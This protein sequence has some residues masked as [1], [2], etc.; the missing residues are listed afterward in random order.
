MF[1]T[2]ALCAVAY[3]IKVCCL[4]TSREPTDHPELSTVKMTDVNKFVLNRDLLHPAFS[5]QRHFHGLSLL[6]ACLLAFLFDVYIRWGAFTRAR[7]KHQLVCA[8]CMRSNGAPHRETTAC[9]LCPANHLKHWRK[10]QLAA[11][12]QGGLQGAVGALERAGGRLCNL[13][14]GPLHTATSS[15]SEEHFRCEELP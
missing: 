12:G 11:S 13:Q 9:P 1:C 15:C 2:T 4:G 5:M 6:F 8:T 10:V 14:D 7:Y 3:E